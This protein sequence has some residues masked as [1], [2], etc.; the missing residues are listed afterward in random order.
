MVCFHAVQHGSDMRQEA[1]LVDLDGTLY[2]PWPVKLLM[3]LELLLFGWK[4]LPLLIQFRREHERQRVFLLQEEQTGS[5][6][7]DC[8]QTPYARQLAETASKAKID[9]AELQALVDQWMFQRPARYLRIFARKSFLREIAEFKAKGGK[10]ALVSDYPARV[11]LRALGAL[12]LFDVVVANGEDLELKRP[13]PWP[14]GYRL[15][16]ERLNVPAGECLVI[17]DREG[18]DG[19][20]ARRAGMPFRRV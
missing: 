8:D 14:D 1:W 2:H 11:K 6:Q 5:D 19:E 9:S 15:A 18:T 12:E 17:G 3:G 16:A 7:T 20:A 4:A 10:T 13:K